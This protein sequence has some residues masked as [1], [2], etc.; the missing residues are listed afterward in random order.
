MLI[1][2][3]FQIKAMVSTVHTLATEAK[4]SLA[5]SHLEA[6]LAAADDIELGFVGVGQVES[7]NHYQR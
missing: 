6:A 2:F 1:T 5:M 3:Q 7:M 4:I